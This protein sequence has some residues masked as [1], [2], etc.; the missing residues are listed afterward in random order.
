MYKYISD[1]YCYILDKMNNKCANK[2]LNS[3][4]E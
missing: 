3:I 1:Y 4:N 2:T